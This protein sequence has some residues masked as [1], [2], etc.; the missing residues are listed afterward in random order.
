MEDLWNKEGRV[1]PTA[2]DYDIIM[3]GS[4]PTPPLR[5]TVTSTAAQTENNGA[6]NGNHA[7]NGN[8]S[9]EVVVDHNQLKDQKELSLKEN[10]ELF[11]DR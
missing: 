1:K 7:E 6:L 5:T 2:L 8:G 10:L 11:V 4:F 3:D 9:A